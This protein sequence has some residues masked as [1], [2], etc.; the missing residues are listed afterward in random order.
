MLVAMVRWILPLTVTGPG[1]KW[2][3][4]N[5]LRPIVFTKDMVIFGLELDALALRIAEDNGHGS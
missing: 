1:A 5:R 2:L 3:R 4:P